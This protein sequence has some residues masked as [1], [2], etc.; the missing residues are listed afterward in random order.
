MIKLLCI[1]KQRAFQKEKKNLLTQRKPLQ[2]HLEWEG[3]RHDDLIVVL[4]GK[5]SHTVA[6]IQGSWREAGH[7]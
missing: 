7:Q 4:L 5:M 3:N 6:Q 1:N 2:L